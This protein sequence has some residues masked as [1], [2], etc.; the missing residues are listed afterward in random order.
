M[1]VAGKAGSRWGGGRGY[2]GGYA[3]GYALEKGSP[4]LRVSE[5]ETLSLQKSAK[6]RNKNT[7]LAALRQLYFVPNADSCELRV[8]KSPAN[9]GW[10]KLFPE[11]VSVGLKKLS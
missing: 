4:G 3:G 11:L 9:A 1:K 10:G 7:E 6:S 8:S 2:A 5:P